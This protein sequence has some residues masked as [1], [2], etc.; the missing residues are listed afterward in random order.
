DHAIIREVLKEDIELVVVGCRSR[1]DAHALPI[2][3]VS[4]RLVHHCPCLVW[5]VKSE[6]ERLPRSVLVGTDLSPVG[7][8]AIETAL[9][10]AR[11]SNAK[12]HVAHAFQLPFDVQRAGGSSV[13]R[14]ERGARDAARDSI[15]KTLEQLGGYPRARI[16]VARTSPAALLLEAERRFEIELTVLGTVSRGGLPGLILGNTA[17]RLLDRLRNSILAVKPA[18]FVCALDA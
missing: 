10:V 18:D 14:Y 12:L 2:G 8:R 15:A 1:T 16:H 11:A 4:R 6:I 9:S 3:S 5:V 13:S 7:T 17:E